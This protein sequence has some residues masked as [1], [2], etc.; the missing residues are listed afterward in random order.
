MLLIIWKHFSKT[1]VTNLNTICL[2]INTIF[3]CTLNFR[4]A[5]LHRI[6]LC[7]D[8]SR[9]LFGKRTTILAAWKMYLFMIT[10]DQECC[11]YS[12]T[13]KKY[14]HISR[15]VEPMS[16]FTIIL[17]HLL[18]I[19]KFKIMSWLLW[20]IRLVISYKTIKSKIHSVIFKK[21][22]ATFI[23]IEENIFW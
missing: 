20:W 9:K 2:L 12:E 5:C 7:L 6:A 14:Q 15:N 11:G 18:D 19:Y 13:Y 4:W 21:I 16:K 1:I 10:W 8:I 22:K 3:V 23:F 17:L